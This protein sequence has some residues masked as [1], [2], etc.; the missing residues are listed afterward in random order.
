MSSVTKETEAVLSIMKGNRV[1]TT[2]SKEDIIYEI[3]EADLV[4][5]ALHLFPSNQDQ[6]SSFMVLHQ[7]PDSV[8]NNLL[9]DYEIDPLNLSTSMIV[10]NAC[11][12]GSGQFHQGEGMLSLSRSFMLAGAKS[13]INALWSV[14]DKA[15]S[16]IMISFYKNLAKGNS[17]AKALRIAKLTYLENS[18]PTFAHPYYW[19]GYQ[20]IGNRSPL[21]INRWIIPSCLAAILTL[22]LVFYL[23]RRRNRI[24]TT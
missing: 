21:L 5:F 3:V 18:T 23:S 17:K 9:F 6:S 1:S 2:H 12:S 10:I 14:D 7:N 4:H 15:G 24:Q 13:V 16:S 22:I 8:L 11:E 20:L 19:A